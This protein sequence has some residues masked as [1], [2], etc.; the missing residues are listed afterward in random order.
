MGL[1]LPPREPLGI[2]LAAA[3]AADPVGLPLGPAQPAPE[4]PR[5]AVGART[6]RPA[7]A[8]ARGRTH[9]GHRPLPGS[10]G[11]SS[12]HAG[13][14]QRLGVGAQH[15]VGE[16]V[17][18]LLGPPG[19]G[20]A[21]TSGEEV[22]R[23][24]ARARGCLAE[25]HRPRLGQEAEHRAE[26]RLDPRQVSLQRAAQ[27]LPAVRLQH[28]GGG[29]GLRPEQPRGEAQRLPAGRRRLGQRLRTGRSVLE[30]L[31]QRSAPLV[32]GH[33][34]VPRRMVQA[35]PGLGHRALHHARRT[36]PARRWPGRCGP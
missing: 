19:P 3:R 16:E 33:V 22:R 24:G 27:R 25:R 34:A 30:A 20:G 9:M 11:R 8:D 15:R 14:H 28:P 35:R 5:G 10:R 6:A 23:L 26:R 17:L 32:T 7:E 13:L 36:S 4:E 18:S 21:Q 29:A 1:A 31:Q 2:G 12:V